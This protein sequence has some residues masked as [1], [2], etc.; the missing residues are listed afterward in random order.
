M[1][2]IHIYTDEDVNP[3]LT[4]ILRERGYS[5]TTARE[6]GKLGRS[7]KEHLQYATQC[8]YTIMTHN[9][10]D[11]CKLARDFARK[12]INHSG[13]IVAPQWELSKLLHATL[14]LLNDWRQRD[15]ASQV[16]WL[17]SYV[18]LLEG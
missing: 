5:A 2:P 15:P 8:R 6:C 9:I 16:I 17:H 3:L 11:F 10:R 7:D 12:Q 4:E 13:I 1:A 14:R 18:T